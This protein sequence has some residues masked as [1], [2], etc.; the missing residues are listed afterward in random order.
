MEHMGI[1]FG[2]QKYHVSNRFLLIWDTK[3]CDWIWWVD[4]IQW[5]QTAISYWST[6]SERIPICIDN[7]MYTHISHIRRY[8]Y[9]YMFIASLCCWSRNAGS[10]PIRNLDWYYTSKN[11]EISAMN[12]KIFGATGQEQP[13]IIGEL[14]TKQSNNMWRF[15][16]PLR[17]F[18]RTSYG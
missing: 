15:S 3:S 4:A 12:C 8:D 2:Q 6:L 7:W 9:L 16:Q 13:T 1:G 5:E 17:S 18:S 11:L 14:A 10:N